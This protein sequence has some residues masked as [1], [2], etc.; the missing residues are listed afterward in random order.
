MGTMPTILEYGGVCG[1]VSKFGA[2]ACQAHGVPAM[3]VAQPGHCAMIWRSPLGDWVLENDNSGWGQSYMHDDIQITWPELHCKQA[4]I[5][6]VMEKA[7]QTLEAF[8]ASECCRLCAP[9]LIEVAPVVCVELHLEAVAQCKHNLPAWAALI[10]AAVTF[11][12]M[13]AL[14]AAR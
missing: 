13:G 2:S 6:P 3:P 8:V 14:V 12:G 11:P 1:A 7:Q 10:D 4:G 5:I 9:L